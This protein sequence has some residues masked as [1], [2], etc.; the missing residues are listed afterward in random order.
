MAV[1][2]TQAKLDAL[3]IAEEAYAAINQPDKVIFIQH[4]KSLNKPA[5][6]LAEIALLSGSIS[7]AETILLHNGLVYQAINLNIQ[8]HNWNRALELAVKHK[9]HIDTVLFLRQNYL[10]TIQK[11]ENNSKFLKL[12]EAVSVSNLC[13]DYNYRIKPHI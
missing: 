13:D 4:I 10:K 3:E 9:T 6:K 1:L 12:K 5:Q 8:M 11:E 7:E 2:A